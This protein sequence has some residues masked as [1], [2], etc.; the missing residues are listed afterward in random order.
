[1]GMCCTRNSTNCDGIACGPGQA[2]NPD[3]GECI[4]DP[5]AFANCRR[6]TLCEVSCGGRA[7]CVDNTMIPDPE[8][9]LIAGEGGCGCRVGATERSD[10][11]AGTLWAGLLV[12]AILLRRRDR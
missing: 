2:C 6:G 4:A 1:M 7:T 10:H 9:V 3:D 5:C 12:A 11:G 8:F